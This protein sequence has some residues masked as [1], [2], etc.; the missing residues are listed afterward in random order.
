MVSV[1]GWI[2]EVKLFIGLKAGMAVIAPGVQEHDLLWLLSPARAKQPSGGK[3]SLP[4][5]V[6]SSYHLAGCP[7]HFAKDCRAVTPVRTEERSRLSQVG[8]TYAVKA[9]D[10]GRSRGCRGRG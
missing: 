6:E 2:A 8:T 1:R 7:P 10:S 5:H 4:L 9:D 3:L